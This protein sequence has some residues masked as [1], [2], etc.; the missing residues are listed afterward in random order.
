MDSQLNE[1]LTVV[2]VQALG[3]KE[4]LAQRFPHTDQ[5]GS[6]PHTVLHGLQTTA[7][8]MSPILVLVEAVDEA[9]LGRKG[10]RGPRAPIRDDKSFGGPWRP[11]QEMPEQ[12]DGKLFMLKDL[13]QPHAPHRVGGVVKILDSM[14]VG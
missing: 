2:T 3:M 6:Q 1:A 9:E 11:G 12:T 5:C 14:F 10:L 13:P 4:F 8:Q 7:Q